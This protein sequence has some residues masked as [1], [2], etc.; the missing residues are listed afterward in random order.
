MKTL[1]ILIAFSGIL[2]AQTGQHFTTLTWNDTVNPSGTQYNAWRAPGACPTTAPTTTPPTGFTLLN[3]TPLSA[4]TYRDTTVTAGLPY[5]YVVT[6]MG[7]QGQSAPSN[8]AGVV[9]P[10]AFPVSGLTVTAQ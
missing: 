10:A 8:D 9:V 2:F 7:P 3:S 1:L 6:A 5:C 4:M